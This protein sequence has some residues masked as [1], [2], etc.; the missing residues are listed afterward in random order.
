M[1]NHPFKPIF[2]ENIELTRH[3]I[4]ETLID[5][6][7]GLFEITVGS[8][9]SDSVSNKPNVK[10]TLLTFYDSWL[11]DYLADSEVT[12]NTHPDWVSDPAFKPSLL[13]IWKPIDQIWKPPS[14]KDS[15]ILWNEIR[16]TRNQL[17]LGSD[18]TQ[19]PD[20][21]FPNKQAWAD[22]RQAL[23]D[24]TLQTNPFAIVWPIAP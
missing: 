24:V 3:E 4:V 5:I 20:V 17:L 12:V 9:T 22:Y 14:I 23:R 2:F 18:W 16:F 15:Q 21:F 6:N 11:P 19:M 10:T 8:W 7:K 1:I 13:H